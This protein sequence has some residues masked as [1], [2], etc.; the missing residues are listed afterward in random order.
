MVGKSE[1]V[2]E[3]MAHGANA[4]RTRAAVSVKFCRAGISIY[5]LSVKSQTHS[6]WRKFKHV[7][8]YCV[9]TSSGV[10]SVSGINYI[11]HVYFPVA[12][13]IIFGKV[14]PV[15]GFCQIAGFVNHITGVYVSS[16]KIFVTPVIRRSTGQ[17]YWA[18]YVKLRFKLSI[19]LW[20][21]VIAR[22]T[23]C[24]VFA[25]SF[26]IQHPMV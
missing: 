3:F 10:L 17:R 15:F 22:T 7:R 24:P 23:S 11:Y 6:P 16:S 26:L 8:P 19:R 13:S 12:I 20:I 4:G 1:H 21:I 9:S 25:K 18:N 5:R 14:N 2:P